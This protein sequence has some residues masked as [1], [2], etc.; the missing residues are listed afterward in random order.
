MGSVCVHSTL[1]ALHKPL[2]QALKHGS[3][4][5]PMH[6][7]HHISLRTRQ[8]TPSPIAG[9]KHQY[10]PRE[11]IDGMGLRGAQLHLI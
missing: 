11:A 5:A 10:G 8:L 7:A 1:K 2:M 9:C 6:L 3:A 4:H